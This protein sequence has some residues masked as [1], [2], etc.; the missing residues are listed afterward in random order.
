MDSREDPKTTDSARSK[1]TGKDEGGQQRKSSD[2]S[3]N[4][5]V[6]KQKMEGRIAPRSKVSSHE[7]RQAK[8]VYKNL[9]SEQKSLHDGRKSQEGKLTEDDGRAESSDRQV[10]I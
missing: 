10:S 2:V 7:E 5:H 1:P 3:S 6:M 8:E 9:R 4:D